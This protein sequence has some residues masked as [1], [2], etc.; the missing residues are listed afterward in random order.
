[1]PEQSDFSLVVDV[2]TVGP[3]GAEYAFVASP[4]ERRAVADRL[5][6]VDLVALTG[7]ARVMRAAGEK[8]VYLEVHFVADVV[9]SCVVTL[10]PVSM[11]LEEDVERTYAPPT[12]PTADTADVV[13]TMEDDLTEPLVHD[14]LDIGAA[15]I[16]HLALSLDPYP[17][18]PGAAFVLENQDVA[19]NSPFAALAR[20]KQPPKSG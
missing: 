20:L 6:L 13:V 5:G 15:V 19:T 2:S 11:R 9:Q 18:K 10:E 14:R 8:G 17:R 12:D 7:T 1:M 3:G 4:A 16:E